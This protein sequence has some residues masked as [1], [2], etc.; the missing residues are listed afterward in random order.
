[1]AD[2]SIHVGGLDELQAVADALREAESTLPRD[3]Q[4]AIHDV[5]E[6]LAATARVRVRSEPIHGIRQ[7][8]LREKLAAGT[9]VEDTSDGASI[10]V[11]PEGEDARLP[12]DMDEG[13]WSHPVFGNRNR[14]VSQDGYFSWFMDTMDEGENDLEDALGRVIDDAID[15]IAAA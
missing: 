15:R 10:V 1:M 7:T 14:W 9:A 2:L 5:A 6:Q 13:G 12:A 3:F 4:R 8:G 11:N